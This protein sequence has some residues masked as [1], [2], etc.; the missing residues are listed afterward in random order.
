MPRDKKSPK[1]KPKKMP[2]EALFLSEKPLAEQIGYF[3]AVL[4]DVQDKMKRVIES[5]ELTREAL[6]ADMQSMEERLTSRME[7]V[8]MVVR[9]HSQQIQD[10]DKKVDFVHQDLGQKIDHIAEKVD[11]HGEEIAFLKTAVA[12]G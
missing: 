1:E 5:T 6:S 12:Q 9:S 2:K 3:S 10:L 11:R 7:I 8:E 4:E